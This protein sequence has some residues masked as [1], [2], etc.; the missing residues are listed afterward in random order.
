MR[1]LLLGLLIGVLAV[2]GWLSY[3]LATLDDDQDQG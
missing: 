3:L 2:V 1:E